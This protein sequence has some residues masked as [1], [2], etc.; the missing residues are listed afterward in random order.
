MH[1]L[2]RYSG[3]ALFYAAAAALT[4]YLATH[5][6]YEPVAPGHAQIKLS[7]THGGERKHPCR[8]L[9]PDE[10]AKLPRGEKRPHDCSRERVALRTQIVI[11][12]RVLYDAVLEPTGLSRDGPARVYEKFIV[13]A[14]RRQIVVRLRD[15]GGSEGFDYER[16][17]SQELKPMQ[18][19]AI[20][21]RP[22]AGGFIFQ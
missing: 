14:G 11:D 16:T 2:L 4:G 17:V 15:S 6:V 22:E 19:L 10:I 9:T 3:Q 1:D 13:P 7:F 20:D 21:F 5:P 18:N 12:D 8:R